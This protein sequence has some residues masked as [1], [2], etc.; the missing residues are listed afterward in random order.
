MVEVEQLAYALAQEY[1]NL[2]RGVDYWVA[3][4]V[5]LAT[6]E[7]I[8]TAWI[9]EWIPANPPKPTEDQLA[10]MWAKHAQ[11]HADITA[12]QNARS[13]RDTLLAQADVA[14]NKESDAGT[15]EQLAKL[16]AYRQ[17]LRDVPQQP[18][19]PQNINWPPYPTA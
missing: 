18:G 7:Q 8:G 2:K 3:H 12:A 9:P 14:I 16:R 6:L 17:A 4:P 13:Q 15:S 10:A 11:A 1:P 5:N 19:F